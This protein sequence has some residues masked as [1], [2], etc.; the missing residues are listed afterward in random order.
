MTVTSIAIAQLSPLTITFWSP[1]VVNCCSFCAWQIDKYCKTRPCY[2]T[3]TRTDLVKKQAKSIIWKNRSAPNKQTNLFLP[4]KTIWSSI[5]LRF[6]SQ[7]CKLNLII[8]F[9]QSVKE[10]NLCMAI[11]QHELQ[12]KHG[13][14]MTQCPFLNC[15]SVCVTQHC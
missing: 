7:T 13:Q 14:S 6:R 15:I 8:T 11:N 3:K 4:I 10:T 12:W 9:L 1:S 5:Y 2:T